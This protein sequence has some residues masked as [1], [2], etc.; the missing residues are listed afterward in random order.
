MSWRRAVTAKVDRDKDVA[1][2]GNCCSSMAQARNPEF[3]QS[4]VSDVAQQKCGHGEQLT[5]TI[6]SH[7]MM[8][9]WK[10]ELRLRVFL[11]RGYKAII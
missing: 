7:G 11:N 9:G 1:D 4:L 10:G 3:S 5:K 6:D 2:S 8:E